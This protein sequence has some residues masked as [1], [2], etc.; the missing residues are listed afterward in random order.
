MD[1]QL[2]V[3][4]VDPV[5]ALAA[6]VGDVADNRVER[7]GEGCLLE[8]RGDD[9]R[10]RVEVAGQC[11][12]SALHLDPGHLDRDRSVRRGEADVDAAA[13]AGLKDVS[14]VEAELPDAFPDG[15]R[16][17]RV[18]VVGVQRVPAGVGPLGV[19]QQFT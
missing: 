12:C 10:V 19:R 6:T 17:G 11:G 18:G 3:A 9:G 16:Q 5:V 4:V 13:G 15:G 2:E 14:A 1:A 8:P 7:V